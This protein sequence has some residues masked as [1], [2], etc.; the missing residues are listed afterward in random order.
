MSAICAIFLKTILLQYVQKKQKKNLFIS[1]F[2]TTID[3]QTNNNLVTAIAKSQ[4]K[5][6]NFIEIFDNKLLK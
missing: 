5:L 1:I 6:I 4:K 2:L 3:N